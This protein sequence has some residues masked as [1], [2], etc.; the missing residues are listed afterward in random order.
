MALSLLTVGLNLLGSDTGK[1]ITENVVG[2][3]VDGVFDLLGG[4]DKTD[5]TDDNR[6]GIVDLLA[7]LSPSVLEK[8]LEQQQIDATGDDSATILAG[9]GE[10]ELESLLGL[11]M[12][13][14]GSLLDLLG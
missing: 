10:N 9:L 12:Q 3:V 4:K 6:Q 1:K 11:L 2:K 5:V 14:E 7:S 13:D 8:L